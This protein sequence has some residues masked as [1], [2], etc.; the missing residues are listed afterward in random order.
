MHAR[1]KAAQDQEK[2]PPKAWEGTAL[3]LTQNQQ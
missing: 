1:E 3:E 2:D